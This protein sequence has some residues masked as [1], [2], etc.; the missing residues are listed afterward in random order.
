[1]FG[2]GRNLIASITF[3]SKLYN[4]VILYSPDMVKNWIPQF[5]QGDFTL[6]NPNILWIGDVIDPSWDNTFH[7]TALD[8]VIQEVGNLNGFLKQYFG[9]IMPDT[10]EQQLETF[11]RKVILF[12]ENN[13]PQAKITT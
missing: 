2:T 5:I 12:L 6:P 7:K 1:M 9:G 13:I 11:F 3:N 8:C 4:F 10:W